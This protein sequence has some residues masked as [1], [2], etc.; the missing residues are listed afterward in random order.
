MKQHVDQ[1]NFALSLAISNTVQCTGCL[2]NAACVRFIVLRPSWWS[3]HSC[4]R[5]HWHSLDSFIYILPNAHAHH[6]CLAIK[7]KAA[8]SLPSW[9]LV[10]LE[11]AIHLQLLLLSIGWIVDKQIAWLRDNSTTLRD[12]FFA[13][14]VCV[15][16]TVANLI[17]HF[18]TINII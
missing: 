17:K 5:L 2:K 6:T 13:S 12:S 18:K 7:L 4:E 16:R 9:G 15:I 11:A 8:C 10:E 1:W 14:F 3:L